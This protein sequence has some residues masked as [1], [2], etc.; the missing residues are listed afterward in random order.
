MICLLLP[1]LSVVVHDVL[2][3]SRQLQSRKHATLPN[4]RLLLP[5]NSPDDLAGFRGMTTAI[6][7]VVLDDT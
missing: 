1:K 6:A 5:M 3:D 7:H 4:H 2:V